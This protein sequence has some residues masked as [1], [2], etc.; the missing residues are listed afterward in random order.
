MQKRTIVY[1]DGFNLYYG[2]LRHSPYK[3]LD[4]KALF[5][6]LLGEK[7]HI[8]EIKYFTARISARSTADKSPQRQKLYLLALQKHIPELTIYYGHFLTSKIKAKACNPSDTMPKYVEVFKTEEKGS[9]VHLALQILNDAWLD[10]YDCA[11]LV[12]NDS[13]LADAL[14]L[15]THDHKKEI[16]LLVPDLSLTRR[17]SRELQKYAHFTKHIRKSVLENAQL[18][19]PILNTELYKPLD[20]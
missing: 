19:S 11:V 2:C 20:W 5:S 10:R 6:I 16:G 9:D 8:V 3:W 13:D 15:V 1:V 14:H 4:L 12:S 7:H 18:P 17:T